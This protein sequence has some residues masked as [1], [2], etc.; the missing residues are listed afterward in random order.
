MLLIFHFVCFCWIF[1]RAEN[2][3]RALEVIVGLGD[4]GR[5]PTLLTPFL[6]SLIAVGLAVQFTPPD[7]LQRLDRYYQRIPVWGVGVLTGMILLLLEI[8]GGDG[9]AAFIYFQF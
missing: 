5:S 2:V 9:T 3:A 1:F 4:F 6:A 8:I 7:L